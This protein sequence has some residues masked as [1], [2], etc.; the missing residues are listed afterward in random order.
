MFASIK[1]LRFF[2]LAYESS[3]NFSTHH[4]S[5]ATS[6]PTTRLQTMFQIGTESSPEDDDE[7]TAAEEEKK[8]VKCDMDEMPKVKSKVQFPIELEHRFY[9]LDP[10]PP[11]EELEEPIPVPSRKEKV[12]NYL[13]V[14]FPSRIVRRV[15]KCTIAYFLT[16]L[17]SLIY[18]LSHALGPAPF[19]S[20]TGMLFSHPGRSMGA[21]FDATVTGVL[22]IVM[23][24]C[25]ALAGIASSVAYNTAHVDSYLTDHPGRVIN[26][27]FLFVGVFLAQVLRQVFPK[28][29][30]FS[31]QFMII[32]I[33]SMT[34]GINYLTLPYSL[35]LNYG[36]PLLIGHGI[37]LVVNLVCWPETAVDGLGM[38]KLRF[39]VTQN[40]FFLL[41]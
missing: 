10:K 12:L 5:P 34:K 36:V 19:L 26:A 39:H 18:P 3:S 35:P 4:P 8:R 21:Q 23:A 38:F 13:H 40:S 15:L 14:K 24:I 16:T 31:L 37:S 30:F 17:F 7:D 6:V 9:H 20:T 1:N 11:V 27:I 41:L 2:D 28:F 29:H 25:Y 32:Q 33:F 22:G